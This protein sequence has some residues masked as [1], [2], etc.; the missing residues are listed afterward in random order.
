M[1]QTTVVLK[2]L[3][4]KGFKLYK[5]QTKMMRLNYGHSLVR[6]SKYKYKQRRLLYSQNGAW[7]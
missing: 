6:V 7:Y 5:I 2:V 3:S 4:A 1:Q